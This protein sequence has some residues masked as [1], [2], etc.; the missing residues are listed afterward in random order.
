[1]WYAREKLLSLFGQS[2]RWIFIY[3]LIINKRKMD[4]TLSVA[5]YR[6]KPKNFTGIQENFIQPH[7]FESCLGFV[8]DYKYCLHILGGWN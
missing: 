5:A 4:F 7:D 8:Q 6:E 1:M 2:Y 3:S